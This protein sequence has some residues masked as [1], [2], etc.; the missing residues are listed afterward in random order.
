MNIKICGFVLLVISS[1][2]VSAQS[3][4]P[5]GF[6]VIFERVSSVQTHY[7]NLTTKTSVNLIINGQN[8]D[9][10]GFQSSLLGVDNNDPQAAILLN[11]CEHYAQMVLA[12]SKKYDL[13][14]TSESGDTSAGPNAITVDTSAPLEFSCTLVG[15][16][17]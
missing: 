10:A 1:A 15:E 16:T 5:T 14:I 9:G 8:G 13:I 11:R 4:P 17:R 3:A 6:Q 2:P 7:T 12:D